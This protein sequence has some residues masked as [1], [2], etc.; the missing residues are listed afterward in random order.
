MEQEG[1]RMTL[2][3]ARRIL[4]PDSMVDEIEK[5]EYY[6]GFHGKEKA[7]AAYKEACL[8]ACDAIDTVLM[9]RGEE[10]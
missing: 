6:G 10:K 7:A 9:M 8:L 5:I 1:K 3:E 2:I 4:H